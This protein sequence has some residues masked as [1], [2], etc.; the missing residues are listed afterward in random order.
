VA[1]AVGFAVLAGVAGYAGVFAAF[2][3]PIVAND[4]WRPSRFM[5]AWGVHLGGYLGA[6]VGGVLAVWRVRCLRK[7]QTAAGDQT[8]P[9]TGQNDTQTD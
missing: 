7:A 8:Q 2:F 6:A 5:C 3:G 4:M 9:D 1:Y